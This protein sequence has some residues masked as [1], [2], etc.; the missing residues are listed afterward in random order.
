MSVTS[1]GT[2]LKPLRSGGRLSGSAGS[3]GISI[4]L[5]TAQ[6]PL[7]L[8]PSR[9]HTQIDDDA[10][11]SVALGRIVC[12]SQLERHLLFLAQ[13][14]G[15]AVSA[16]PQIKHVKGVAVLTGQQQLGVDA[17]FDHFRGAPFARD[18]R[19]PAE[20]PPEVVSQKLR[21]A[22]ELPLSADFERFRIEHENPAWPV[23]LGRSDGIH[24]DPIRS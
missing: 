8:L 21:A 13:I 2:A 4:T 18:Q 14:D 23:A 12:R 11:E 19:V 9:N 16:A 7:P 24:I 17:P 15:L 6:L 10:N 1:G 20:M 5:R 22:V 3:A